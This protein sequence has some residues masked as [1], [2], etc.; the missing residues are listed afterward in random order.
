MRQ[1]EGVRIRLDGDTGWTFWHNTVRKLLPDRHIMMT[2]IIK[3]GATTNL[4]TSKKDQPNG[5]NTDHCDIQI[6]L[7]IS[8]HR[9]KIS[10]G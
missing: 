6:F 10:S 7:L 2:Y 9:T 8:R 4:S 5:A 1:W 3:Y